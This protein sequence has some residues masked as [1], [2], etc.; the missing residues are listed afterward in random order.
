M[1]HLNTRGYGLVDIQLITPHTRSL[2][3]VT[4]PRAEYLR[5]LTNLVA[6][7]VTFRD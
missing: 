3:A 7:P 5:R 6:L 2:G 1:G 4:I